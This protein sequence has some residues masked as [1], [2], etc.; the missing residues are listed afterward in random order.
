MLPGWGWGRGAAHE[1]LNQR[2]PYVPVPSQARM[3]VKRGTPSFGSC[4]RGVPGCWGFSGKWLLHGAGW[5]C[6]GMRGRAVLEGQAQGG[7]FL[8]N[9]KKGE[10]EPR[11]PLRMGKHVPSRESAE[12]APSPCHPLAPSS[13]HAPGGTGT[14]QGQGAAIFLWRAPLDGTVLHSSTG[15]CPLVQSRAACPRIYPSGGCVPPQP[16]ATTPGRREMGGHRALTAPQGVIPSRGCQSG[17]R[18]RLHLLRLPRPPLPGAWT[19]PGLSQITISFLEIPKAPSPSCH[20][21]LLTDS[22]SSPRLAL[23]VAWQR[24][25]LGINLTTSHGCSGGGLGLSSHRHPDTWPPRSL[26]LLLFVQGKCFPPSS[27]PH[28][29][30]G[31]DLLSCSGISL[32]RYDH[33]LPRPSRPP[34]APWTLPCQAADRCCL[35]R[36]G[37][38]PA[39]PWALLC[40]PWPAVFS[41]VPGQSL[42]QACPSSFTHP[43]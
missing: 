38:H 42:A 12:S 26:T 24:D 19:P 30:P 32:P 29:C 10:T 35:L 7:P 43:A 16:A 39:L 17:C 37:P 3:L 25:S 5:A 2:S 18:D 8:N 21:P 36:P 13:N 15:G 14:T 41:G 33:P 1:P 22:P 34:G 23:G 40:S 27:L 20:H 6:G 9:T 4:Q 31:P 11:W 28:I